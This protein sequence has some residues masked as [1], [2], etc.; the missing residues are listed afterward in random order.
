MKILFLQDDFP[1]YNIGGAA[2]VVYNLAMELKKQGNE[3]FV[4][5][6]TQKESDAISQEYEGLK[7]FRVYSDYHP[8]W[9]AYLSL[10]NPK[11]VRKAEAIMR[12]IKPDVVHIHNVH[13]YLSYH[14]LKIAKK[15]AKAVFLTAHDVM[16]VHYG[17]LMPKNKECPKDFSDYKISVFEQLREARKRYNPLRNIMIRRYLKY[18]DKICAVSTAI[19]KILEANNIKN[20][21]VVYNGINV[22]EWQVEGDKVEKFKQNHSLI[23]KKVIFFA[24]KLTGAK[25]R[26]VIFNALRRVK[27]DIPGIVLIIA[28]RK[29]KNFPKIMEFAKKLGISA[30]IKH[31]G[32]L[33]KEELKI[34]YSASDITVMP[35]VYFEPFG[36]VCLEAMAS[37]KPVIASCFG[38]IREVVEDNKTGYIIN[39]YNIELFSSKVADLLDNPEKAKRFGEE[40]YK[41]AR[42]NFSLEKQVKETL[43]WYNKFLK[44]KT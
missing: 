27:D 28:G 42:D 6:S 17:K 36:M 39:P 43:G 1:P 25:G 12:S 26:D 20:T 5:T 7:V 9:R 2:T 44:H 3:V 22:S 11:T 19:K 38:G 10:C 41:R 40:G 18:I 4:I 16:L 35:S 30:N 13:Y 14:C 8:R 34:A 37:K 21:A 32:W 23:G 24:G 15:Y 29:D 31:L 33:D